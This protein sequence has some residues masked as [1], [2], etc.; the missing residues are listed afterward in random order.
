MWSASD[1]TADGHQQPRSP[2]RTAENESPIERF[3]PVSTAQPGLHEG[4]S[5][6]ASPFGSGRARTWHQELTLES[7]PSRFH[8][9]RNQDR[10]RCVPSP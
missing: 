7:A 5:H 8:Q 9:V 4:L 10:I 2:L 6:P 3:D 1:R